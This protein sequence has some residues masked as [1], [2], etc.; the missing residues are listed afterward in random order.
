MLLI[1][2]LQ[3]LLVLLIVG[4]L[5]LLVLL[6]VGCLVLLVLVIGVLVAP[7]VR[8]WSP[9]SSVVASVP[10]IVRIGSSVAA[11]VAVGIA[12]VSW[13]GAT[14]R[15]EHRKQQSDQLQRLPG[16]EQLRQPDGP[17]S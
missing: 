5:V 13:S 6:I 1:V 10:A 9:V 14:A 8:I 3:I 4:C 2:G 12:G 16:A 7:V 17:H 15:R 11:R